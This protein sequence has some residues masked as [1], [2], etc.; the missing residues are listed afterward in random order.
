LDARASRQ[1]SRRFEVFG[2]AE[3]IGD[4]R[5]A[6][7]LTPLKTVGPPRLLRVGIRIN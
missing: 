2:A 1:V 3:N 4:N 7:G 6:A 5:C